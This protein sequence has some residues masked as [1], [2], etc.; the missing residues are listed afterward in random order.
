VPSVVGAVT[1][2]VTSVVVEL[3]IL[4]EVSQPVKEP[5]EVAI[6]QAVDSHFL[7]APPPDVETF[8]VTLMVSPAETEVD[9]VPSTVAELM[10]LP[11]VAADDETQSNSRREYKGM[12]FHFIQLFIFIAQLPA[13]FEIRTQDHHSYHIDFVL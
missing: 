12:S 13:W 2:N 4:G 5:L 7:L 11:A 3:M 1:L 10:I 6:S 9:E 8:I